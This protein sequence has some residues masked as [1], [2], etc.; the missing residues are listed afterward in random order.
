MRRGDLL[1]CNLIFFSRI[2]HY[3]CSCNS[4]YDLMANSCRVRRRSVSSKYVQKPVLWSTNWR[5]NDGR[6][7]HSP[8]TCDQRMT[9]FDFRRWIIILLFSF[10]PRHPPFLFRLHE[11][12][13][14]DVWFTLLLGS[15]EIS[16]GVERNERESNFRFTMLGTFLWTLQSVLKV[17]SPAL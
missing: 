12:K 16:G 2:F 15:S 13:F 14:S 11:W 5:S 7:V 8:R 4:A 9:N 6:R 17:K 10:F 1:I 3:E